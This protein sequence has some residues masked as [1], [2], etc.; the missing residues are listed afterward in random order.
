LWLQQHCSSHHHR[1]HYTTQTSLSPEPACD[2]LKSASFVCAQQQQSSHDNLNYFKAQDDDSEFE[3]EFQDNEPH[4]Q[5]NDVD[6]DDKNLDAQTDS[7]ESVDV[8]RIKKFFK[9]RFK[10]NAKVHHMNEDEFSI[11][12]NHSNSQR[13]NQ[14]A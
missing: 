7:A 12:D 13:A 1:H 5:V 10:R 14:A 4:I 6:E 2:A 8:G 9:N 11:D 3:S